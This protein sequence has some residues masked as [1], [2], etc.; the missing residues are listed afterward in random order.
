MIITQHKTPLNHEQIRADFPILKGTNRGK[1]LV[2]LDSA[3]SAQKPHQVI[4]AISHFYTH[5]YANI[6]RGI[7]EL[8]TRSTRLYEDTREQVKDFIHAASAQEIVFV[9]GTTEAINLVAQSFGRTRWQAGDEVILSEM[10]HH[11]NIVPWH[12][13]REQTGIVLRVI[14]VLDTGEL[15]MTAYQTLLSPRTKL[16]SVTHASNVLGVINP[17]KQITELAHAI[18]AAVLIDGAQAVPH[19]PVNVQDIGCDFYVFSSHKCY[20]P[21]GVGVLYAKQPLLDS[22]PPWQG[23]GDMIETVSFTQ[24]SYAKG[25]QKFEAGTPDIASVI[26]FSAAMHYL[27]HIG[28]PFITTHEQALLRYAESQLMTV[29]GLRILGTAHPKVGVV[30]FVVDGIHPHDLGTVLDDEGIAVRA[31]H[32]C[33]MPLM[34]R[35][36]VP[37]TVRASFGLYNTTDDV[38]A[39]VS[40][41][42]AATRLFS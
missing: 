5:D 11:A 25:P 6:H 41:I 28:F 42:L 16:V 38:D 39:L 1:P 27:Q 36:K 32:H 12:M 15:D 35:F 31:G 8:S 17:V 14:P 40:G 22:M 20:G 33:A 34:E 29:P 7:Y 19:L 4:E 23:G 26:G 3:S 18:G 21:T 9:R 37:A 30:S 13:L 10:E 24:V 2:Y